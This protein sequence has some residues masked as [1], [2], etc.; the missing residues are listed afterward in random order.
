MGVGVGIA[1][2]SS[3]WQLGRRPLWID[4]AISLGAT[5]QLWRAIE[6][7]GGTM[8]LYYVL[9][10]GWTALVGTS[11]VELRALSLLLVL[12]ALVA[13]SAVLHRVL[14]RAEAALATVVAGALPAIV[15]MAQDA[16]PYARC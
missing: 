16:R 13:A 2:S 5:N 15:R 8:A 6:G 1:L 10:D 4:E 12:A 9:L 11:P 7:T 3:L 14:P